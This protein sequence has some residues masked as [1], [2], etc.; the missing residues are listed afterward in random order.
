MD[1]P[2]VVF[3]IVFFIM[4]PSQTIFCAIA[5]GSE[6]VPSGMNPTDVRLNAGG[7]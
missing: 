2:T 4:L 5:W 1:V 7:L 6:E 3:L